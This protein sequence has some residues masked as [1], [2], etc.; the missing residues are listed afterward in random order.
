[1]GS[2]P[3]FDRESA[4]NQ[5]DAPFSK[6]SWMVYFVSGRLLPILNFLRDEFLLRVFFSSELILIY[7]NTH[8]W[9]SKES[10]MNDANGLESLFVC[11]RFAWRSCGRAMLSPPILRGREKISLFFWI[12]YL[13]TMFGVT[14]P[15]CSSTLSNT[16]SLEGLILE[17][18]LSFCWTPFVNHAMKKKHNQF[19]VLSKPLIWYF[20]FH[21]SGNC[22][23]Q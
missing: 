9:I 19:H 3:C 17:R 7:S 4:L 23:R 6:P 2:K 18:K 16:P 12:I 21:Q 1:M 13:P 22:R 15:G 11:S 10:F 20:N 5:L 14:R 8:Y